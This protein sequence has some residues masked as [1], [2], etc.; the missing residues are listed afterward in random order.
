MFARELANALNGGRESIEIKKFIIE[1]SIEEFE[2]LLKRIL[3]F[4]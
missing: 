3:I 4:L 1:E 2:H